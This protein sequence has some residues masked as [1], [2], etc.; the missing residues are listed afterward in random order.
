VLAEEVYLILDVEIFQIY[1][2]KNAI[3]YP[4]IVVFFVEMGYAYLVR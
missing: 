1:V 4:V 3:C 2:V